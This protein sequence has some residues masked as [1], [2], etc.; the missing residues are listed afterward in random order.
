MKKRSFLFSRISVFVFFVLLSGAFFGRPAHAQTGFVSGLISGAKSLLY[1]VADEIIPELDISKTVQS[2]A[3]ELLAGFPASV[4]TGRN[5]DE[6]TNCGLVARDIYSKVD[7][8]LLDPIP[9]SAP[10]SEGAIS[11]TASPE[12]QTN[13]KERIGVALLTVRSYERSVCDF[14]G[15]HPFGASVGYR[16]SGSLM[17]LSSTFRGSIVNQPVPVNMAYFLKDYARRIPLINQTAYAQT[18]YNIIGGEIILE[19][20]RIS[21]NI[22]LGLMSLVLLVVG[23]M[24]MTRK[25]INPQAVVTLQNAL[26]RIAIS[27]V[28]VFFSYPIGALLAA[29]VLPLSWSALG[30]AFSLGTSG[31]EPAAAGT[32]NW[33]VGIVSNVLYYVTGIGLVAVALCI[34]VLLISLLLLIILWI[35]AVFI[36]IKILVNII[37]APLQ[38]TIG[39]LPGKEN[40]T[41]DWFKTMIADV[42]SVPAMFALVSIAWYVG[43][44]A[45]FGTFT[46]TAVG[47]AAAGEAFSRILTSLFAP[48][49]M[50]FCLMLALKAP[51]KVQKMIMGDKKR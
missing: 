40:S 7:G 49:A 43:W 47:N 24:I 34:V 33:F 27:L 39:I 23:V 8:T 3:I 19:L 31:V 41:V 30:I 29:L 6:I 28:L 2:I 10:L 50:L 17:A 35:R 21:R 1:S 18:N 5:L 25:K 45:L 20:W 14:N 44:R 4:I 12:V 36:Y 26:P 16:G 32:L 51:G 38:F 48:L 22:S 37:F 42:L 11:T 46:N 9:L 13:Q 15:D